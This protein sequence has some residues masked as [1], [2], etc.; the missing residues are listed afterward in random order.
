MATEQNSMEVVATTV[1]EAIEKGLD[2]LKLSIDDV[3]IETL[4]DGSKGFLGLGMRQARILITLKPGV[5]SE[6]LKKLVPV[7]QPKVE[8]PA[9]QAEKPARQPEK[10]AAEEK[11]TGAEFGEDP[12]LQTARETVSELLEKMHVFAQVTSTYTEVLDENGQAGVLVEVTGDDLSILIGRKSE[13][14]NSLQYVTSLIIGKKLAKWVPLSIDVEG[15]RGRRERQL[16]QLALRM[17]EQAVST[18]RRQTLEPMPANERRIIHLALRDHPQVT[19]ESTGDE[20][21]RKLTIVPKKN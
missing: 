5:S 4:D 10:P 19:T 6:T 13:T 16:K 3:E 17:A 21:N 12:I 14:L 2:D 8:K 15:Y 20:P 18:G 7:V 9:R 1:E 11:K